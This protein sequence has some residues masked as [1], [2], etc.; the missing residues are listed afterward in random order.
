MKLPED[1]RLRSAE[2]LVSPY[3]LVSRSAPLPVADGEP[4]FHIHTSFLGDPSKVLRSQPRWVHNP[5]MGNFDGAGGSIDPERSR[6]ISVVESLERYSSCSW[7]DE[8]FVF[9]READLGDAAIS[10]SRWPMCSPTELADPRTTLAPYDP[11]LPIRWVRGWSLTR[12]REVMVPA[13]QVYLRFFA[14]TRSEL[15]THPVST[16]AADHFDLHRAVLGGLLEVVERDSI[17]LTWLQRM[18]LPPLHVDEQ[19]LDDTTAEY[20]RIANSCHLRT[21]LYDATTDFGIPVL[22]AVQMSEVDPGLSQLVAATCDLDPRT[23]LAKLYRELASLR[24]ALRAYSEITA[25][26]GGTPPESS[27]VGGAVLNATPDRR[28]VFDF[29]LR[30]ETPARKL[31]ELARYKEANDPDPLAWTVAQLADRGAE[32]VVVDITTDEARQVGMHVVKVLVP[33]AM[34]L[35]FTH[36]ARYLAT[37]RLYAAPEAMGHPVHAEPDI[38]PILQPFA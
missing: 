22:Y 5:A 34:P 29:L 12:G 24:I 18:A 26:G 32:V 25:G 6:L 20:Y 10:P 37:P 19:S 33:E 30:S 23:A 36:H 17:S 3:G 31:D 15:F 4:R 14:S 35:S 28:H 13:V 7:A 38:N 16:G 11:R 2:Q 9:A 21:A 1:T 27:V 8:D